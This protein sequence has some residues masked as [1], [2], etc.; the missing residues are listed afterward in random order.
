MNSDNLKFTITYLIETRRAFTHIPEKLPYEIPIMTQQLNLHFNND[1][2]F[3]NIL[4]QINE[5]WGR[6]FSVQMKQ[7]LYNLSNFYAYKD[8]Q[9]N[10]IMSYAETLPEVQQM[11]H[12]ELN[13]LML[14]LSTMM[15][16]V[17]ELSTRMKTVGITKKRRNKKP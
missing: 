13:D 11:K 7:N 5:R 4:Q 15:D 6:F 10:D 3:L 16:P 8:Q 17:N 9:M 1:E 14:E 12:A 2:A